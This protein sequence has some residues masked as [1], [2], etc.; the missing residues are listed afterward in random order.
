MSS[1]EDTEPTRIRV[2]GIDYSSQGV[3]LVR[4]AIIMLRDAGYQHL[5]KSA[6]SIVLFTHVIALLADYIE[7]LKVEERRNGQESP[8]G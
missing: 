5:P 2:E 8:M 3:Q 1:N 7:T 6:D 4:E